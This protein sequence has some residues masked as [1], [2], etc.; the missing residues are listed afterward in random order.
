MKKL[1]FIFIAMLLI[2]NW[3]CETDE[4]FLT[5]PPNQILT[6]EQAFSD[7]AQVLS[8]LANLYSR[9][10][11]YYRLNDWATFGDFN[12]AFYAH[13]QGVTNEFHTNTTWPFGGIRN[14]WTTWDYTYI[15]ELN[16]FLERI[17]NSQITE[18][19]KIRHAAEA[20]YLRA[21]YYLELAQFYGGVPII[22]ESQKY[23]FSGDPS[24]LQ[25]PRST[26]AEIYDFI[27]QEAESLKVLLPADAS[28]K[29]RATKG[30]ALAMKAR[31]AIYAASL[32]KYNNVITPSVSLPGGE[33]GIPTDRAEAYYNT[34]LEASKEII[35][36]TAGSYSLYMKNPTNLSENFSALFHDK[37]AN[38]EVIFADDYLLKY[39]THYFTGANQPRFGAEEEEGGALNP[40]LNLVQEFEL[41]DNTFSPLPTT[42]ENGEPIYYE[43]QLDIFANRDARL[44]GTVILP[45]SNFKSR[46]VDIWAGYQLANGTVISGNDRGDQRILPGKTIEQQVVGFDGPVEGAVQNAQ[47]GFYLRKYVDPAPGSG[48]RGIQSEI[49]KIK[50]RYSEILLI[51][52]EAA[53][54]L[55]QPD[56]SANYLNMVRERAGFTIPLK[57]SDIS[58]D[59]IVHERRVEFA[60]EGLYFMDLKRFRIAHRIFD[61]VSMNKENLLSEIGNATKRSTMP[62]GLWPYRI[63]NPG[64]ENDGKWIYKEFLSNQVTGADNWQLG[65]Y[66]SNIGNDIL[67]NNP[68]IVRQPLQ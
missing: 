66:Y 56:I 49:W 65:N 57:G 33:V 32:A 58:F 34:A 61:G 29:S 41:L 9:Q 15:R 21:A 37:N 6:V 31:A 64:S 46:P 27:I 50:Y 12:E 63:Y 24:Y 59:R 13:T 52:A 47:M 38:P 4:E 3:G 45:G 7:P 36:G 68:K 23:D 44:A 53:F 2:F 67:N 10:F 55:G 8:I 48:Q 26:E 35:E 30:A 40:S 1:Y 11:S 18:D 43:S 42:D 5:R 60:F 17:E 54:E 51:A 25:I 39:R 62:W 14:F 28:S 22:L 16:L 20:R 19:L